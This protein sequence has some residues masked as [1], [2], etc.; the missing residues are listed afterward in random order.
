[1]LTS[2]TAALLVTLFLSSLYYLFVI[3]PDNLQVPST[4]IANYHII[5]G[6]NSLR[7]TEV[8]IDD[9]ETAIAHFRKAE[10]G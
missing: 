4:Y 5:A 2:L 6:N 9:F 8:Q 1:M 10:A 7:G 3:R